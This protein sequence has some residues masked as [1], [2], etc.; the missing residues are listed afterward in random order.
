MDRE[1]VSFLT[2]TGHVGFDNVIVS[3][4][5]SAS[6]Y[7]EWKRKHGTRAW[8]YSLQDTNEERFFCHHEQN[9]INPGERIRFVFSFLSK[10]TGVF[11]EQWQLHCEPPT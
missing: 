8:T 11:D 7:Y 6:I 10:V 3:N 1:Y 2:Q 9:V 5:G 4:T